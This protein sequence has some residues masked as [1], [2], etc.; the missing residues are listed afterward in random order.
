MDPKVVNMVD[1]PPLVVYPPPDF[2]IPPPMV[3]DATLNIPAPATRDEKMK[4]LRKDSSRS[5][6]RRNSRDRERSRHSPRPSSS[7]DYRSQSRYSTSSRYSSRDYDSRRS[8]PDD[9][10]RDNYK[11]KRTRSKSPSKS[12]SRRS[13]PHRSS[14]S[15]KSPYRDRPTRFDSHRQ[16]PRRD[17]RES[18]ESSKRPPRTPK[19]PQTEREK[20]LAKWRKNY[21]ETSDQISKKLQEMAND[22]EQ[23]SWIRASPADIHYK[24]AKD[25]VV[26]STPR[27]DALCTLFDEEL[28]K[29][30]EKTKAKQAPYNIPLR[31][32]NIRVCRH[33]CK[34]Q[35]YLLR[36]KLNNFIFS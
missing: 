5:D 29:R 3:R 13:P 27:L 32:R 7:R 22:E 12:S 4:T 20:L 11:R 24:R 8:N 30:A 34:K 2:S 17:T 25:N 23:V 1:Q 19:D 33:K 31:R 9:R 35:L 14:A 28:L 18:R 16:S 15:R 21:C 10:S 6:E 26:V 36:R